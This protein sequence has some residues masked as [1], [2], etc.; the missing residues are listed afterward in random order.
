MRYM[1][2]VLVVCLERGEVSGREIYFGAGTR[3]DF[4]YRSLRWCDLSFI[5]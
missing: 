2:I 5:G 1:S 3:A 4:V